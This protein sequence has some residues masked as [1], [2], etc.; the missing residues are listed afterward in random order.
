M[1]LDVSSGASWV[2]VNTG[3]L[4]YFRS[5]YEAKSLKQISPDFQT[6]FSPEERCG[7]LDD[8]FSLAY[9]NYT[10][11]KD[12]FEFGLTLTQETHAVPWR[13]ADSHLKTLLNL[14]NY[15]SP[16]TYGFYRVMSPLI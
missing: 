16:E 10:T 15:A 11:Y 2:K 14:L 1:N 8:I 7:L 9:A 5:K 6:K 4:G 12:A 13:C 3:Q